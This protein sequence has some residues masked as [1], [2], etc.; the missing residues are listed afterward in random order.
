ME[1]QNALETR[2]SIRKYQAKPVEPEKIRQMI[3]A[4]ILAPSWKNSQVT[5]YYV[6]Q[7]EE[8]LQ[9]VREAL[10][11]FNRN[12][13]KDAPVLIVSTI[14]KGRSGYNVDGTASNELE[15]GWGCYDCG[16]QNMNLLLKATELGLGTLV[17]GIRDAGKLKEVF[18]IP[19]EEIVVSVI[20]VGYAD[21]DPEM[22]KRKSVDE[23]AK[24]Y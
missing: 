19:E 9:K 22:P 1:L 11:E 6:A 14:V 2:R 17:M 12:N 24:F 21:V 15:D 20:G 10:P 7:S 3:Q 4:A 8:A 16:M 5:R 23:T 18:E 13:T